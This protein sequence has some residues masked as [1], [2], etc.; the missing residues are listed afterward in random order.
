[1]RPGVN[2]AIG[3]IVKLG[4]DDGRIGFNVF[5]ENG[6]HVIVD[7]SGYFTGPDD[8]LSSSGLF[9][10]V[11]PSRLMD[12]RKGQGGKK[13]LWPGWTRAFA[14]PSAYSSDAGTAV[15][16]VTAARTMA[17]GFFSVNA[18]QTRSGTPTTS[19]L[20]VSGPDETVANHVVSRISTTGLEVFSS[21]GGDV[22]ADLV[23]YYKGT[24]AAA[25]K[26]VPEDPPPPPIAPPYWMVAPSISRLNSGRSVASGSSALAVV[27]S[28]KIWHWTGTGYVGNN[29]HNVAT[30]G[31][32]TDYG[33]PLYFADRLKAGDR[34]YVSTGDQRTYVYKYR[35]RDLTSKNNAQILAATQFLKGETLSLIACTVGYDRSKS[36][37]PD[38]WAPTSLEYRIIVTFKLEY[39]TDDIPLQ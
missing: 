2:R 21:K 14:M 20:N 8:N 3:A 9:V 33:G 39:W 22:I 7:V 25:T 5:V 26:P 27:N 23:G 12:T 1:V 19:S 35:R 31:H 11:T 30:F 10:P 4:T 32:R 28:G 15:L 16:N 17:R 37:Y 38:A 29:N 34:V 36:A 6:A 13:R 18:A 24:P